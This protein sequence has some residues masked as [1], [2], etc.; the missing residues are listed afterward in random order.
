MKKTKVIG[1][2]LDCILLFSACGNDQREI[3]DQSMGQIE[4]TEQIEQADQVTES[5]AETPE[6]K[7]LTGEITFRIPVAYTEKMLA[8]YYIDL[9]ST[10]AMK[11]I[12]VKEAVPYTL[13]SEDTTVRITALENDAEEY[14]VYSFGTIVSIGESCAEA[15]QLADRA[16]IVGTVVNEKGQVIW[17]RGIKYAAS[18]LKELPGLST[19]K[20]GLTGRQ[21]AV[22][23]MAAY[24]NLEI[25]AAGFL[26]AFTVKDFL[27][28]ATGIRML[29]LTG[30][31]LD[32][33]LYF[34][35]RG[36][37][38]YAMKSGTEAIVITGYSA[39]NITAYEPTTGKYKV[40]SLREAESMFEDAGNIFISYVK[41]D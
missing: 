26:E 33:V 29:S 23:M 15:V 17:E 8:E 2:I 19:A 21:E 13:I 7:E 5:E 38:V 30:A 28:Q 1:I 3:Y 14:M 12:P 16:D 40:Y 37:P 24:L 39:G 18:Y 36:A 20:S 9:P 11:E 4:Q 31:A 22:R 35:F 25:D 32:E 27:E 6:S 10:Y 41:E 34:V